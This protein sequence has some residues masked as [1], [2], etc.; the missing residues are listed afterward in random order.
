VR[1]VT[2]VVAAPE[3][4][5]ARESDA[6]DAAVDILRAHRLVFATGAGVSTDSGIPDYRGEGSEP[7]TPMS[8][9]Q[10]LHDERFR[11]RYW[12]GSQLGWR[13]FRTLQPNSAHVAIASL[14]AAGAANGVI[15]QNV[16][17]LHR[18]AGSRSVVELHGTMGR[19]RCVVCG[20]VV[21]RDELARRLA[22]A[23]PWLAE[24]DEAE[25]GPDGDVLIDDVER[26]VVPVCAVCGGT[27]RPDIVYF[28][29]LVP[30]ATF[31]AAEEL[32][33]SATALVIA[34]TSL[35]VNS[36]VRILERARRNDKPIIIINRGATKGD[37]RATLKIDA[38]V[39]PV[40]SALAQR[41][42]AQRITAQ[43]SSGQ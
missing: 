36:G 18:A 25:L 21:S 30:R 43:R 41:I 2:P 15:T 11:Q 16:D 9:S 33:D 42:T 35:V 29:E 6:V 4:L 3:Q 32:V 26:L 8:I 24:V 28:G 23:N 31:A 7:R 20:N 27:L 13:R 40:L 1:E 22:E 17:G 10:F 37:Q 19:A 12:A 5:S 38:G 34:G 14:E 39:G